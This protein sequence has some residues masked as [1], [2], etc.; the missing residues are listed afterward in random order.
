MRRILGLLLAASCL[1]FLAFAFPAQADDEDAALHHHVSDNSNHDVSDDSLCVDGD[2]LSAYNSGSPAPVWVEVDLGAD[3]PLKLVRLTPSMHPEGN[4][5]V[6][7]LGRT[8]S[9][10]TITLANWTGHAREHSPI[11]VPI[12]IRTPV[13]FLN[14]SVSSSASRVVWYSIQAIRFTTPVSTTLDT[15]GRIKALYR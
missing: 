12:N 6:T 8:D 3:T 1:A 2:S 15:W 14:V 9:G 10:V 5:S 11:N 4:M 7:I 13:R